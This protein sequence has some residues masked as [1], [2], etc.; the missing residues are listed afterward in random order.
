MVMLLKPKTECR[1][2]FLRIFLFI[3]NSRGLERWYTYTQHFKR[4]WR[5]GTLTHHTLSF[6]VCL[7]PTSPSSSNS[8]SLPD[9]MCGFLFLFFLIEYFLYI[10]NAIPFPGSPHLHKTPIPS[11]LPLLL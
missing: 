10:S 5:D 11:P 6:C 8:I 1:T 7:A 9:V 3:E 2:P 4:G